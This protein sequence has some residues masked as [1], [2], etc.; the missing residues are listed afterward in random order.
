M[1]IKK[2]IPCLDVRN[3]R[4]VKGVKFDG[5][6]D[7]SSPVEL[8]KL[9]SDSGAD[10]LVFYDITA[11]TE[12][13]ELFTDI[14]KHVIE[15]I[16]V[17]LTVGGGINTLDDCE[18]IFD[19]GASKVSIN[20]GALKNPKLIS[21][22][23]KKYGSERIVLSADIKPV[24]SEYYVFTKGGKES[25][26]LDAIEWVK[27]GENLGAGELV[28]NS[29]DTDGMKNGFDI[30]LL[31][32]VCKAVSIPITASGG[33]GSIEDFITL[34][35]T[36]PQ[37]NAGLAASIF[38]FGIVNIPELKQALQENKISVSL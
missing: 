13:R 10:E 19:C 37:I 3:G 11:S 27:Q 5:I 22:A 16:S 30:P 6:T 29:I 34:F 20:S 9:Y 2:I 12:E 21:E 18:R 1:S 38:H 28:I 26:E 25:T 35:K 14:L 24:D 23:A 4:V 36:L 7:V 32:E 8:A 31:E 15:S 17:P 33:A